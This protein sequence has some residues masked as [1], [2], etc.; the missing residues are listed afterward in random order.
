MNITPTNA[1]GRWMTLFGNQV[2]YNVVTVSRM[3]KRWDVKTLYEIPE[4]LLTDS[5]LG[6]VTYNNRLA[7]LRRFS[8][9]CLKK[10][11]IKYDIMEDLSTRKIP[12]RSKT[13]EPYSDEQIHKILNALYDK[14][15]TRKYYYPYIKFMLLTGVRNGEAAGLKIGNVDFYDG[16]ILID[17]SYSRKVNGKYHLKSTKTV[18]GVR[19]IPI[20]PELKDLLEPLCTKKDSNTYVFR[21]RFGNPIHNV[22]F[23][24][25]VFK[26]LLKKLGIPER[27][28]YACRHT[29][30]TIA[31]EQNMD[32]LSVAY[33]MG[34]SKPRTVLDHYAKIRHRPKTLPQVVQTFGKDRRN[35]L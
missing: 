9:W 17:K 7:I 14:P 10:K 33:L 24:K 16:Y 19:Y 25:R 23:Q 11:L 35:D 8:K 22:N 18:S 4:R 6:P 34:H 27:D 30:G 3:I 31:V 12:G 32:I 13:R 29:F 20:T 28:L 21:S 1:Y 2:P 15:Y 26:P 5:K